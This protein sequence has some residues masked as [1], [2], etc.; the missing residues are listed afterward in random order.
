M[1]TTSPAYRA[2][3]DR[4]AAF[5]IDAVTRRARALDHLDAADAIHRLALGL[6]T[7]RVSRAEMAG[8]LA[9]LAVSTVRADQHTLARP[10]P[11]TVGARL[12]TWIRTWIPNRKNPNR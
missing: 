6:A 1:D 3:M 8:V 12:R 2:A 4:N 7:S 9:A 11:T 10:A 5:A